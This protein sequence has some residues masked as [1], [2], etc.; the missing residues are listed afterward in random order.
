MKPAPPVI[1]YLKRESLFC[2][3]W[4]YATC[5]GPIPMPE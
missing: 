4:A 5:V 2:L 3:V 1:K